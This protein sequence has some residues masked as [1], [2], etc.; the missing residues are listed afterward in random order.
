ES[1]FELTQDELEHIAR[2]SCMAEEAFGK[3]QALQNP[4]T[5]LP[6]DKDL[7]EDE[8]RIISDYEEYNVK[9]AEEFSEQ[10]QSKTSSA[11]S[12]P[13]SPQESVDMKM[14]SILPSGDIVQSLHPEIEMEYTALQQFHSTHSNNFMNNLRISAEKTTVKSLEAQGSL[15]NVENRYAK[16]AHQETVRSHIIASRSEDFEH[17]DRTGKNLD[18]STSE[19]DATILTTT[20]V[21]RSAILIDESITN[22][23]SA[24]LGDLIEKSF[25]H[26]DIPQVARVASMANMDYLNEK[27]HQENRTLLINNEQIKVDGDIRKPGIELTIEDLENSSKI[28]PSVES[29]SHSQKEFAFEELWERQTE[30]GEQ[31]QEQST[32]GKSVTESLKNDSRIGVHRNG[33]L[34]ENDTSHFLKKTSS[35]YKEIVVGERNTMLIKDKS[36]PRIQPNGKVEFSLE[37]SNHYLIDRFNV[38]STVTYTDRLYKKMTRNLRFSEKM[39]HYGRANFW[40]TFN[41]QKEYSPEKHI[42]GMKPTFTRA[43]SVFVVYTDQNLLASQSGIPGKIGKNDSTEKTLSDQSNT[44]SIATSKVEN[45]RDIEICS[46]KQK[47]LT[48]DTNA[49]VPVLEDR[50]E[51]SEESGSLLSHSMFT[52]TESG[53]GKESLKRSLT[54]LLKNEKPRGT[55]QTNVF[56]R[57]ER[58]SI[59]GDGSMLHHADCLMRLNFFAERITEQVAELAA[60]ELGNRFRAELNPRAR[61]FLQMRANIETQAESAP[62]TPSESDE[63]IEGKITLSSTEKREQQ[64]VTVSETGSSPRSSSWFFL[65]G[66]GTANGEDRPR[67]PISFLWRTSH[68]QSDASSRRSSPDGRNEFMDLLR[69]TSGASS[70]GSDMSTKLPDSALAGLSSEERE[71]IEKVL[72]AANRRSRSSQSTPTAS[73]RQSI[74]KLPD[75]NDFEL[76]E[77]VHIEGVIEKAEKGAFP[78]VIKVTNAD[79]VREDSMNADDEE[80]FDNIVNQ[81]ANNTN[82]PEESVYDKSKVLLDKPTRSTSLS[83]RVDKQQNE[84]I[85][86]APETSIMKVELESSLDAKADLEKSRGSEEISCEI[87]DAEME[88]IR[89]VAEAAMM[90]E[91]DNQ[92][93]SWSNSCKEIVKNSQNMTA[94]NSL[95][96]SKRAEELSTSESPNIDIPTTVFSDEMMEPEKILTREMVCEIHKQK[97]E[98][99]KTNEANSMGDNS[100]QTAPSLKSFVIKTNPFERDLSKAKSVTIS[101]EEMKI[102]QNYEEQEKKLTEE[103]TMHI[104]GLERQITEP[105]EFENSISRE[106][107]ETKILNLTDEDL[108]QIELV[109]ERAKQLGKSNEFNVFTPEETV[110]YKYQKVQDIC[111]ID[112]K[113]LGQTRVAGRRIKELQTVDGS[114][115]CGFKQELLQTNA[116]EGQMKELRVEERVVV[117]NLKENKEISLSE[118]TL[119]STVEENAKHLEENNFIE[120]KET[121]TIE[122]HNKIN[123]TT[124]ELMQMRAVKQRAKQME[125][126]FILE[127]YAAKVFEEKKRKDSNLVTN[128]LAAEEKS[129]NHLTEAELEHIKEVERNAIWQLEMPLLDTTAK[130]NQVK[131]QQKNVALSEVAFN[132]FVSILNPFK[133]SVITTLSFKSNFD[134]AK[135]SQ[136]IASSGDVSKTNKQIVE[137]SMESYLEN[138]NFKTDIPTIKEAD[139]TYNDIEVL[140]TMK[141]LSSPQTT[142]EYPENQDLEHMSS[143]ESSDFGPGTSDEDEEIDQN[144]MKSFNLFSGT[145]SS[146]PEFEDDGISKVEK[147]SAKYGTVKNKDL[148]INVNSSPIHKE[149]LP[150]SGA[151]YSYGISQSEQILGITSSPSTQVS[152]RLST[153]S[154]ATDQQ[155]V[156]RFAGLTQEEIEHIK[157]VDLHFEL[158]N[159]K[160]I[161]KISTHNVKNSEVESVSETILDT[162]EYEPQ[163]RESAVDV[164]GSEALYFI[165]VD[166]KVRSDSYKGIESMESEKDIIYDRSQISLKRF[167]VNDKLLEYS[168]ERDL[169][170]GQRNKSWQSANAEQDN[171]MK[172]LEELGR[173]TN[174]GKWYEE[175]LSSLRNSLCIEE[176]PETP[177]FDLKLYNLTIIITKETLLWFNEI[178]S[179]K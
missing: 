133:N 104:E 71:H 107:M 81:T 135:L 61:Y 89:K 178:Y 9:E 85:E 78:F 52:K 158:E 108:A 155:T 161:S 69:R 87:S 50:W 127:G 174:I 114:F 98:D 1:E 124:A 156:D 17:S 148:S 179:I 143:S 67:S 20:G 66:S 125:E 64:S 26:F 105:E 27:Q 12:G 97:V 42:E 123:D 56:E 92:W 160:D 3:L 116:W 122:D 38:T 36:Y 152:V 100:P 142:N 126:F 88:H 83:E 128:R 29:L 118:N 150:N 51:R 90:M 43:S 117:E 82:E 8:G 163:E 16:L 73:R 4:Q 171:K 14:Y 35:K 173:E 130:V 153:K 121:M 109:D 18:L 95:T 167:T 112:E 10:S 101:A 94:A 7:V 106:V 132:K 137:E 41:N 24:L 72:S 30:Q 75:M 170:V 149:L 11:T 86:V 129:Q 74:Y 151:V 21:A 165:N 62:I 23:Q 169:T 157:M 39:P 172:S 175:R 28:V 93:I 102:F 34:F 45:S 15:R 31:H 54:S 33:Q 68:R 57:C 25:I 84:E 139:Y 70:N 159:A 145:I 147:P 144:S 110:K 32:I 63:E 119:I 113:E 37:H 115:P 40:K 134:E 59:A 60:M 177:G 80:K 138:Q 13:D 166:D 146:V 176:T 47:Y 99:L 96:E 136:N 19:P 2:V 168:A 55:H 76:C 103:V 46:I 65:F 53:E 44:E 77:R 120:K 140:E 58:E 141:D 91:A 164:R 49:V 111:V 162:E 131:L 22:G 79:T 48:S 154:S 6:T 5:K